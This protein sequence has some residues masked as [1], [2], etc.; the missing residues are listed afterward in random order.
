VNGVSRDRKVIHGILVCAAYS[1]EHAGRQ[2][3]S[4]KKFALCTKYGSS[5]E[6]VNP[7]DVRGV[8]MRIMEGWVM[9]QLSMME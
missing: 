4:C 3:A 1:H 6:V 5:V 2:K 8:D 7:Q 9:V